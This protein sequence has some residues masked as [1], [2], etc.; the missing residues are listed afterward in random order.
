MVL[1][2]QLLAQIARALGV[3]SAVIRRDQ[4]EVWPMSD[5]GF[6]IRGGTDPG[7]ECRGL[8]FACAEP[9]ELLAR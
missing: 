3:A 1:F 4:I 8:T 7:L 5:L 2:Q 9:Q 6:K